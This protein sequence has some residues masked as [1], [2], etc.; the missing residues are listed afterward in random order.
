MLDSVTSEKTAGVEAYS[1]IP[2]PSRMLLRQPNVSFWP[3]V[4]ASKIHCRNRQTAPRMTGR[5]RVHRDL[6]Q[7]PQDTLDARL[8]QSQPA[9]LPPPPRLSGGGI[10]Q[11]NLSVEES[12]PMLRDPRLEAM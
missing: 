10:N 7:R 11:S 5:L 4:N 3:A 12:C 8:P 9:E 6:I 1:E 2:D